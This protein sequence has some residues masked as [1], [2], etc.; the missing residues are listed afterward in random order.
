VRIA[1]TNGLV[2]RLGR[3]LH[4]AATVRIPGHHLELPLFVRAIMC[5][6]DV[7]ERADAMPIVQRLT[8]ISIRVFSA[9]L[10]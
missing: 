10:H 9:A 6:A 5:R 8:S 3:E 2:P 7:V 4:D 1:D